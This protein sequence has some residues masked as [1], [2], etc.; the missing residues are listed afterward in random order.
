MTTLS[1]C[2]R[3]EFTSGKTLTFLVAHTTSRS[4]FG[5]VPAPSMSVYLVI[6]PS[7]QRTIR[8]SG[9]WFAAVLAGCDS[10]G[11]LEDRVLCG[12]GDL[13]REV[14]VQCCGELG[15]LADVRVEVISPSTHLTMRS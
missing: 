13:V 1:F 14:L 7:L 8:P 9:H 5:V 15:V 2:S 4:W 6:S 10:A 12:E 11:V 3:P